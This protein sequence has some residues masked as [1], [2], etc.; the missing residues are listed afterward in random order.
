MEKIN[1]A[2]EGNPRISMKATYKNIAFDDIY[3]ENESNGDRH[4]NLSLFKIFIGV[5]PH[6]KDLIDNLKRSDNVW[7]IQLTV[8]IV[9]RSSKDN[10]EERHLYLKS[11]KITSIIRR[12]TIVL[13]KVLFGL[14]SKL[15]RKYDRKKLNMVSWFL[16]MLIGCIINVI[17]QIYIVVGFILILQNGE[18]AKK[19]P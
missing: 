16:A 9:F 10:G 6:F 18:K 4:K 15:S 1:N 8:K 14:F 11:V 13:I 7:E 12:S 2:I 5:C 3:T 17:R 19:L